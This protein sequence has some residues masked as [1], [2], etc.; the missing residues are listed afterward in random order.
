MQTF[1]CDYCGEDFPEDGQPRIEATSGPF[2]GERYCSQQ[3]KHKANGSGQL[4]D[5]EE[6]QAERRQMG[7]TA[8]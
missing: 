7:L 2:R 6:R 5:R 8:L 4:S 1:T 3:C